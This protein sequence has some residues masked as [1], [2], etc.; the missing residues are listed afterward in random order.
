MFCGFPVP[1]MNAFPPVSA[2]PPHI[3]QAI[4]QDNTGASAN[5]FSQASPEAAAGRKR[6][7]ECLLSVAVGVGCFCGCA[8]AD[9]IFSVQSPSRPEV[10]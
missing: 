10:L 8:T 5:R 3:L 9:V 1:A 2:V 7:V 4:N 6:G